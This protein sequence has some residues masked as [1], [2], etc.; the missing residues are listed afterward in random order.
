MKILGIDVET[1]GLSA[2]TDKITEIAAV[3]Y[4][5]D[6]DSVVLCKSWLI[7]RPGL[8]ITDKI[9]DITGITADMLEAYGEDEQKVIAEFTDICRVTD[10]YMAHNA[11]FDRK[12][13]DE[14]IGMKSKK[15]WICSLRDLDHEAHLG[16]KV[17][18][19]SLE[20][21]SGY[22][23]IVNPFSHRALFDV[24]TMLRIGVLHDLDAALKEASEPKIKLIAHVSFERKD[25]AKELGFGWDKT[26]KTWFKELSKSKGEAFIDKC[27]RAGVKVTLGG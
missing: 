26:S 21:L 14:F 23:K 6:F 27:T 8:E 16:R 9:T 4:D 3:L 22:Y 2:K 19:K 1:S 24:L 11:A 15:P 10:V 20:A 18:S 17:S 5:T 7:K 25:S 12:F 13:V